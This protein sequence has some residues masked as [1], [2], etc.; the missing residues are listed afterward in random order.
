MIFT[1]WQTV[2]H[3]LPDRISSVESM[4]SS[5]LV[6]QA[7][8]PSGGMATSQLSP[9]S[10]TPLPQL[11]SQSLSMSCVAPGGQQPSPSAGATIG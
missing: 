3:P 9:V 5:Q 10:I 6:G 2:E 7:P 1:C 4:P 8:G 11:A